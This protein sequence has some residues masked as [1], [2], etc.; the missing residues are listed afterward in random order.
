[1]SVLVARNFVLLVQA[2][3]ASYDNTLKL[4]VDDDDSWVCKRTLVQHKS[5]VWGLAF[6]AD[7][8]YL[9]VGALARAGKKPARGKKKMRVD[10]AD[11]DPAE[12]PGLIEALKKEMRQAAMDLEFE[13]A[14]ELRDR[15]KVLEAKAL[16]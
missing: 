11:I 16:L 3:S 6:H 5:T 13:K 14:A 1:M 4:W 2:V 9:D 15:V 10:D 8:D 7:G 12:L